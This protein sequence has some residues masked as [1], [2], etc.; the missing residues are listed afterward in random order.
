MSCQ[1][2]TYILHRVFYLIMFSSIELFIILFNCGLV[3]KVLN[4]MSCPIVLCKSMGQF[5]FFHWYDLKYESDCVFGIL[6]YCQSALEISLMRL[7]RN[8][9]RIVYLFLFIWNLSILPLNAYRFFIIK[10]IM[11]SHQEEHNTTITE[12]KMYFKFGSSS[13]TEK[14]TRGQCYTN[15]SKF[16]L[17][18]KQIL[19]FRSLWRGNF[20]SIRNI[21]HLLDF[22][23]EFITEADLAT[24]K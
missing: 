21:Y 8:N 6:G 17:V 16:F 14:F 1:N 7:M 5:K 2:S 19:C 18:C 10:G 11:F 22:W 24:D 13:I 20:M 9:F 12:V 15:S 3:N 23:L 4:F